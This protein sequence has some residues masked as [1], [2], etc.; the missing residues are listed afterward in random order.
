MTSLRTSA[1]EATNLVAA[2]ANW[3]ERLAF[4]TGGNAICNPLSYNLSNKNK[5]IKGRVSHFSTFL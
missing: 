1:R 5:F 2:N 4:A 3:G